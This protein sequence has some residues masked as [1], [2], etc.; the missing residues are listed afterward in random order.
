MEDSFK[1]KPRIAEDICNTRCKE[2][3]HKTTIAQTNKGNSNMPKV[4]CKRK[5]GTRFLR[6]SWKR[7]FKQIKLGKGCIEQ[8][9]PL[10]QTIQIR[11]RFFS[12]DPCRSW[13]LERP[14]LGDPC[15]KGPEWIWRFA[16]VLEE[17]SHVVRTIDFPD[18]LQ[19]NPLDCSYCV[20]RWCGIGFL[21]GTNRL[22]CRID[23]R[24]RRRR[25]VLFLQGSQS[26]VAKYYT[27]IGRCSESR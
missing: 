12:S 26:L 13:I 17:L 14:G 21:R 3:F 9:R 1:Q 15:L 7:R 5:H 23:P 25:V 27:K 6:K 19:Q 10:K 18:M 16:W 8:D 22:A 20:R 11:F 4:T 2:T 24:C